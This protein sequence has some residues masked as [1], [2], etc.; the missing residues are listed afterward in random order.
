LRRHFRAGARPERRVW[1]TSLPRGEIPSALSEFSM[2]C[3]VENFPPRSSATNSPI[4][5]EARRR[6][7]AWRRSRLSDGTCG[8]A[9][10]WRFPGVAKGIRTTY[11][12]FV[13]QKGK[14][15]KSRRRPSRQRRIA[16]ET[17]GGIS[18]PDADIAFTWICRQP[19][20]RA[21]IFR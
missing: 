8:N 21:G 13:S 12:D 10:P 18:I 19:I 6:R 2:L 14:I 4:A 3:E 7:F 1:G 16:T 17:G 5:D 20:C 15:R 11:H 9:R